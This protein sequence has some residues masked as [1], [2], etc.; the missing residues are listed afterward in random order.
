MGNKTISIIIAS[1]IVISGF[2][3]F[4]AF[5]SDVVSA[6][7]IIY[8]GS[9]IGNDSATINV[10]I[11]LASP[12]DTVFVYSG[13]Y[14][15]NVVVDKIINLTG[16]NRDTTIIDGGNIGYGIQINAQTYVNI[17]G[18]TVQNSATYGIY[19]SSSTYCRIENN[20]ISNNNGNGLIVFWYSD[21]NTIENNIIKD[22]TVH[23]IEL[24]QNC[25]YNVLTNN[26][27]EKH[28]SY[29]VLLSN[30]N[31]DNKI[32]NNKINNSNIGIYLY[33]SNTNNNITENSVSNSSFYGIYLWTANSN[34]NIHHN[35][36]LNNVNQVYDDGT[37]SWNDGYP[38][39]GNFWGDYSGGDNRSGPGQNIP[40]ND[41]I[42]DVSYSIPGGTN[43]DNYPL[44][45]NWNA[46]EYFNPGPSQKEIC[47]YAMGSVK[48]AVIFMESN[49][50]IDPE[51]EDWSLPRK[52][53]VISEIQ[54]AL[55]WWEGLEANADLTF[56]ILD[57]GSKNTSYEPIIHPHTNDSLWIGEIM[58]S[59]GYTSGNFLQKVQ[60]YN[61]WLR[62]QYNTDWAYTIFVADSFNDADGNFSDPP[63]CAWAYWEYGCIVETYDNGEWGIS[64]MNNVTAHETGHMFYATDEYNLATEYN[65][66]LNEADVE[67]SGCLMNNNNL[68]LSS[69]T[70]LQIGWR[71]T[72]NDGIMDIL[73]TE[74]NTYL[75]PYKPDPTLDNTPTYTGYAV[76]VP[77][78]NNNPSGSGRDVTL[79]TIANVQY[80]IDA[81]IW[82]NAIPTDGAFDEAI[83]SFQFTT[84]NLVSGVH[85]ILARAVNSVNNNDSTYANDT[86][87]ILS[88]TVPPE[89][90]ETTFGAPPTGD[91]YNITANV[92][93]NGDVD[94]VWLE[95]TI[96]SSEGYFETYNL[97][98]NKSTEPSYWYKVNIW[99][100]VTWFNYTIKAND[101][102]DNWNGTSSINLAFRVHNLDTGENFFTIQKAIDDSD[103]LDGHTIYVENGIY[104]ENVIVNKSINLTGE[105]SENTII[106]G[107][108][109]GDVVRIVA[110]W[111]NISG[112]TV[113]RSGLVSGY[114]GIKLENVQYCI[115]SN[116]D[117]TSNLHGIRLES[118]S[119]NTITFNDIYSNSNYGISLPSS[120]NDNEISN[121]FISNNGFGINLDNFCSFNVIFNNMIINNNYGIGFD[122][123]FNNIIYNNNIIKNTYQ[124]YD[125]SLGN[126]WD[127]GYPLG[128][129]FWS[130]YTGI[131]RYNGPGQNVPGND[132]IGDTDYSIVGG[133]LD[134]FPLMA[135]VGNY[136]FLYEGWNLVS[137]PFIQ[138]DTNLGSVLYSITGDYDAVQWYDA[139]DGSDPWKHNSTKKP[140]HLND[141]D[142]LD[143]IKGFWI[144]IT[145]PNGTLFDYSGNQPTSNQTITLYP[146]WNL[147]SYPSLTSYNRTEGLNNLTFDTHID[148]IWAYNSAA[149]K[150][151]E[152]RVIDN[153]MIGKGYWVHALTDCF[154]EAPI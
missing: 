149:K 111:V 77:Y 52:S 84:F 48:V 104:Y 11:G 51:S 135:P 130:D 150:W 105:D 108:G 72:D 132:G 34:N 71:D 144:H 88:D 146:G 9:G 7:S 75:V 43:V 69:G 112:F 117:V 24:N 65:G 25:D 138:S 95:Y 33:N 116:N 21:N 40:G 92:M 137:I 78:P 37:N 42:G 28:P 113:K 26:T 60:S 152:V 2:L 58:D 68:V 12:G 61:H 96:T 63:W 31:A 83:E 91:Y 85:F 97:S 119:N 35:N 13:T 89:I 39:G 81:G 3:G 93:D 47:E 32:E 6:G 29:G 98:M 82:M 101:T 142:S 1:L 121:N 143:H 120:S 122:D 17:S 57:V 80:Q 70:K 114:A 106:D 19:L 30:T 79:N 74:P 16:E 99:S 10:G 86:I 153:F 110:N 27:I 53:T 5:N 123:S 46:L 133:E 151:E 102:S 62:G 134:N 76:V 8:V 59:M 154:W 145:K 15:E 100:N 87:T 136:I 54:D 49:G 55:M 127:N 94:T 73:D 124:A 45:P 41:G 36:I 126:Q 64:R 148:S 115:I 22:N 141:L 38:G 90:V 128:G 44:W 140:Y 56:S 20:I 18:F 50:T 129:N 109:S 147:V 139:S 107:G 4:I 14:V 67:G 23:G 103:T 131:D 125:A 118:S 66:Y